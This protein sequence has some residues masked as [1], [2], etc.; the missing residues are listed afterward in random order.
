VT[1]TEKELILKKLSLEMAET[2]AGRR[3]PKEINAAVYR[4]GC[5]PPAALFPDRS[6][7]SLN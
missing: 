7:A 2:Q 1:K 5:D 3:P 6:S 4:H